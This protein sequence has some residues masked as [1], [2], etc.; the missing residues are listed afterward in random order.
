MLFK[1]ILLI[2]TH[3]SRRLP[4]QDIFIFSSGCHFVQWSGMIRAIL[5]EG[6]MRGISVKLQF[7]SSLYQQ[8]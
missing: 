3:A 5:V 8:C 6:I 2:K 4:F 7:D 1:D